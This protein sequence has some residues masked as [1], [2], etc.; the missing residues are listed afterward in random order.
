MAKTFSVKTTA[1]KLAK[2]LVGTT[3]QTPK[4]GAGV[5]TGVGV[6]QGEVWIFITIKGAGFNGSDL[7]T[8]IRSA[9]A[10]F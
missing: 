6:Q 4:D 10:S 1:R 7:K 8:A 2:V 9:D 3:I 5:V